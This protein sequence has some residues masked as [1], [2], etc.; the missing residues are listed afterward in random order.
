MIA[1]AQQEPKAFSPKRL[2]RQTE[3]SIQKTCERLNDLWLLQQRIITPQQSLYPEY[4]KMQYKDYVFE[5]IKLQRQ[6]SNYDK[7]LDL[8]PN[9]DY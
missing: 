5:R 4:R 2:R 3:R 7:V 1:A 9:P 6:L 8:N